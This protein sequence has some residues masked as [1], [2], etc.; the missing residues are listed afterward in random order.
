[1]PR[2]RLE[3]TLRRAW[4]LARDAAPRRL[5]DAIAGSRLPRATVPALLTSRPARF[6]A[7]EL[8]GGRRLRRHALREA[9]LW[10][11]VHHGSPDA[12]VVAEVFRARYYAIPEDV[13]RR[14]RVL[15]R[16]LRVV[17][18]GAH[19]GLFGLWVKHA[20]PSAEIL[21]FEPD[22][23]NFRALTCTIR[24]NGAQACGWR[25]IQ[26]CA[27]PADGEL[28]FA[29]GGSSSA[30]VL[31]DGES[32]GV[33]VPARDVFGHLADVDLLKIDIEGGE[34]EL[35][36][37]PRFG[38]ISPALLFLEY[39]PHLC[40][41]PDPRAHARLVLEGFG[42]RVADVFADGPVGLLRATRGD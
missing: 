26:A 18:L 34:W 27:A 42:Y 16:A 12:S 25:A 28:P 40:P 39:H 13:E 38:S 8:R 1:M 19:V 41:A 5:A 14:F 4:H 15:P 30:R 36:A 6:A 21:A 11:C 31:Q 17:D 23:F 33:R 22:P 29:A 35:L 24:A 37:D 3:R 32:D 20:F 2:T 9:P 7:A 10:F